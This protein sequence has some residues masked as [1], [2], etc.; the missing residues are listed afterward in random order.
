MTIQDLKNKIE[1]KTVSDELIIFKDTESG[2]VSNQYI[3][4][5]ASARGMKINYVESPDEL[6]SDLGSIFIENTTNSSS[7]LNVLKSEVFIWGDS[8]IAGLKDFIV[9]VS[10][11]SDKAIE[12]SLEQF[13]VKVPKLESWMIKDYVYS[14][15]PGVEARDLDTL[16]NLCGTN[17]LRLQQELDKIL[18]FTE[19]ERKYLVATMLQ[20]GALDDL[21]SYNIFNLTNALT[22]RNI[23]AL[24]GVYKELD[25][26]DVNEFGLLTILLKNFKNMLLVQTSSNPTPE[27]IGL[28]SKVIYA[29]KKLP[30][31]FNS[32]QLVK[33]Y[34]MLLDIDRLI[35]TGEL[36]AELAIDYMIVKIMSI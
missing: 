19:P 30:R 10:K 32:D 4:A 15:A 2:F 11:F 18:L 27:S 36:P 7:N 14:V 9:V 12:K 25:R 23:T 13:I 31:V 3:H 1:T 20:D 8:R 16:I 21:S 22:S 17:Y 5:I 24:S 34:S 33:I 6:I 28:D 29:I 26:V 35:K